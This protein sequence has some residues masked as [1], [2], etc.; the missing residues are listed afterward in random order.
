MNECT[1][2]GDTSDRSK[3]S[4]LIVS[5]STQTGRSEYT[6][7]LEDWSPEKGRRCLT[8]AE[9]ED[10]YF[11]QNRRGSWSLERSLLAARKLRSGEVSTSELA[12]R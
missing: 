3:P 9:M 5:A 6:G 10:R 7:P 11:V 8:V 12:T 2:C 1:S 4:T